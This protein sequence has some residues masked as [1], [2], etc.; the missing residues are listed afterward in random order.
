MV[1]VAFLLLL[2]E[3]EAQNN[4]NYGHLIYF[5]RSNLDRLEKHLFR[6]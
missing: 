4:S 5:S 2:L 3:L 1:K 6:R